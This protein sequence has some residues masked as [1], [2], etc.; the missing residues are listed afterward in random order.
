[1][2]K[3]SFIYPA[4]LLAGLAPYA[5]GSVNNKDSVKINPPAVENVEPGIS[6]IEQL[7]EEYGG[8][9]SVLH[10]TI[11]NYFNPDKK[12]TKLPEYKIINGLNDLQ[13]DSLSP[14]DSTS[15]EGF[16]KMRRYGEK[17]Y[18]LLIPEK[19]MILKVNLRYQEK[20]KRLITNYQ[21]FIIKTK[22][23]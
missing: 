15:I 9:D 10:R 14:Q 2:S 6:K 4:V 8:I 22:V 11:N 13:I 23:Q 18:N 3:K 21:K 1:M 19:D 5:L 12:D 20:L 7:V 16:L 17:T